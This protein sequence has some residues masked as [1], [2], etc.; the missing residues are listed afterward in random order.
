[1]IDDESPRIDKRESELLIPKEIRN[2]S[3]PGSVRGYDRGAVDA[4]VKSVNRVIAELEIGSSPRAAVR[5]ALEQVGDQTSGI[6]Q[7]AR[8]AAEE[9]TISARQEADDLIARAKAEAAE[10]VVNASTAADRERA[11]ASA[12][13]ATARAEADEI[14]AE[15]KAEAEK[16]LAQA[17]ADASQ[18]LKRSQE[19][20]AA[21]KEEAEARM[22][23]LQADTEGVREAR[24]D[25]LDDIGNI[26]ARLEELTSAAADRDVPDDAAEGAVVEPEA[27]P[28]G[29]RAKTDAMDEASPEMSGVGARER[30]QERP[31][32]TRSR[33]PAAPN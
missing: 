15:A 21:V 5:H 32:R 13:L 11:D 14:L 20:L 6:L 9:I 19:E 33:R 23:E 29:E 28:E 7:R 12:H 3:F 4:Y 31:A 1:L 16:A 26:A 27:E 30:D 10:I 2:V 24:R 8:E 22:R 18:R 17:R 25:L